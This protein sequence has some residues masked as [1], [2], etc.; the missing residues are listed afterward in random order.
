MPA[1]PHLASSP[2]GTV[3]TPESARPTLYDT[4]SPG[5]NHPRFTKEEPGHLV[6]LEE[7]VVGWG[8][9]RVQ[10]DSHAALGEG[11]LLG[12]V[13]SPWGDSLP[14][15]RNPRRLLSALMVQVAPPAP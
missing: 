9:V 7:K 2:R 3:T 10:Q 8:W 5:D 4:E 6:Q 12:V 1:G 11:G 14:D 13:P 15:H